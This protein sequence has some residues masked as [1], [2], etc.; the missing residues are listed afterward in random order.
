MNRKELVLLGA[1]GHARSCIDVI[2]LNGQ[3]EIVGLVGIEKELGSRQFD[4]EIFATDSSLSELASKYKNAI[5]TVGHIQSPDLR[6][7]LYALG[8]RAGFEFPT[9]ISPRAYVSPHAIVGAGTIVMHGA[10]INAGVVV[11]EN[12]IINSR[13]LIEHDAKVGNHVHISTGVILNGEVIV[14]EGT[15]IGS[16]ALVKEGVTVGRDSIIGMGI[17]V[18]HDVPHNAR[19]MNAVI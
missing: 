5:V 14:N 4:Y 18:R 7:R 19:V 3:F 11:G 13:S 16:G 10:I 6:K 17:S 1:G 15:F 8:L 9:V 2:Q 12:C